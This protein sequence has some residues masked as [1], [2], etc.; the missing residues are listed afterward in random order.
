MT[1]AE[2]IAAAAMVMV[3]CVEA[4]GENQM[5]AYRGECPA[6][7]DHCGAGGKWAAELETELEYR[8]QNPHLHSE[9]P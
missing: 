6:Y 7:R 9:R 2:L 5:R 8:R 4:M 3:S 1:E